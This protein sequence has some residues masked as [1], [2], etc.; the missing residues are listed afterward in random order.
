MITIRPSA[1][2]DHVIEMT[3]R[4]KLIRVIEGNKTLRELIIE[5][6][7]KNISDAPTRSRIKNDYNV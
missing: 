7:D 5:E 3:A 4:G 1:N 6:I 2:P